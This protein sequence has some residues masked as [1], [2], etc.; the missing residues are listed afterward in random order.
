V[1]S[2]PR[3]AAPGP[4]QVAVVAT[5]LLAVTLVGCGGTTV[6]TS[7]GQPTSAETAPP[8][9]ASPA[10]S[11]TAAPT[12]VDAPPVTVAA[13]WGHVHNL[14]LDGDR[15]LLG[16]HEGLW[17]QRPGQPPVLLSDAAFDVMGLASDG[18]AL[19]ASG[20]PAPDQQL[21]A[22]LGL[23]R[24]T[25]GRQWQQVS[26]LGEVDFH[27][28]SAAGEVVV[29]LSAHDGALLRSQDSGASWTNLGTPPLYD[30]A[31]DPAD[32]RRLLGTTTQ[33][34]VSSADGGATFA[35]EQDAPLL[36]LLAWTDTALYG[37]APDGVVHSSTDGGSTWQPL[38]A[39]GGPPEAL[40]ADGSRVAVLVG[41]TVLESDDGGRTFRP[42]LVLEP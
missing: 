15:L 23:L 30:V 34:V 5:A 32:P 16:T 24:S 25:D 4:R 39:S 36:A 11:P 1:T 27:R 17:E 28:L 7:A 12:P 22:D 3:P 8:P 26:L 9:T 13:E 10:P 40:A 37:V 42:R 41:G 21:P 2:R 31:V 14:L 6:T 20:H 33:G 38:G 19:L 35:R 29:G 18:T